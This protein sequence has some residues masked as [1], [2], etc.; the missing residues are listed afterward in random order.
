MIRPFNEGDIIALRDNRVMRVL[1]V[2]Y[3]DGSMTDIQRMEAMEETSGSPM[4]LTV[5][6]DMFRR[7][8][9]HAQKVYD[10]EIKRWFELDANGS[11]KPVERRQEDLPNYKKIYKIKEDRRAPVAVEV[12]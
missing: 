11:Y 10:P 12:K 7:I 4:R 8:I 6:N 5:H 1:K 3:K 2:K 9:K